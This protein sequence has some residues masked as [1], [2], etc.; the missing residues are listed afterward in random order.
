MR[1]RRRSLIVAAVLG[2][3]LLLVALA[4]WLTRVLGPT[5]PPI[6]SLEPAPPPPQTRLMVV[7]VH[8][9]LSPN[10]VSRLSRLMERHGFD[11]VVNLSGGHPLQGL[12][13]Q[14]AAARA[15]GGRVTV[16]TSLAYEQAKTS[17]Y[18]ARMAQA[19][20]LAHSQGARGLKIA[21]ALG[22]GLRDR[23]GRLIP[24]DD[25]ELDVVFETA[26]ELDMPIAIHSGDPKAFW[27]PVDEHN[28][29]R[30]ELE[31]HPG[32][33][34]YGEDVPSFD[35]ILTQLE[36]RIARHPKAT[37]IS[38]HFGNAAEEPERVARM[39]RKYPNMF[40]DTAARIPEIGRHPPQRMRAFF[41][42]FQ[43]RILYGSDLGI[44]PEPTPLFL[45][46][47]GSEPPTPGEVERFFSA[48]KRFFETNDR[49]FEHPT[50][51]QGDWK[52]SGIGLPRDVLKKVY[53]DNALRVLKLR[54]PDTAGTSATGAQP[55]P[56]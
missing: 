7:D 31:A 14:L 53:A 9:H 25:P 20:R 35:E 44:G 51:I 32:W 45:G 34:Q 49:D 37:F 54:V 46:S 56:R 41:I 30:A 33:S 15:S 47:S 19:L 38:V 4:P 52:I 43:D 50:P 18:G 17:E 10:A 5:A 13:E 39:L 21:K 40:I 29:R 6:A 42:E 12:P 55:T 24:V 8:V 26:A 22:L 16:F 23:S 27:L 28:E 11:H 3:A 48:T 1:P 36:R 2:A